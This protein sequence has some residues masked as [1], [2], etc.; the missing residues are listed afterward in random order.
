M[1]L[2]FS[3]FFGGYAVYHIPGQHLAIDQDEVIHGTRREGIFMGIMALLTKP[4]TSLGPIIATIILVNYGYDQGASK[5]PESLFLGIKILMFLFPA[6]VS[7]VSLVFIYFYPLHGEALEEMQSKLNIIHQEKRKA[8]EKKEAE[9]KG[10]LKMKQEGTYILES[11]LKLRRF[12]KLIAEQLIPLKDNEEFQDKYAYSNIKI[13]LN[14]RD[15]KYAALIYIF[16]GTLQVI[17]VENTPK[18]NLI[19]MVKEEEMGFLDTTMKIFLDIS[20]GKMT[21]TSDYL[22]KILARK[23]KVKNVKKLMILQDLFGLLAKKED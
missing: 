17:A 5:Q 7:A 10:W 16:L 15:G 13:L 19:Q 9:E 2:I 12:P 20:V 23:L 22:K 8:R 6:I 4:A 21:K 1:G 14:S 3:T 11:K 18:E